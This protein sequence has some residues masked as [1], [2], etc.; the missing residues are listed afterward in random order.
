MV[1]PQ[2]GLPKSL[3]GDFYASSVPLY[4]QFDPETN[5][6]DPDGTYRWAGVTEAAIGS[7]VRSV[8]NGAGGWGDP[9]ERDP[10]LVLRDVRDEYVT[11][12]G[13]NRDYGAV[14]TGDP[15]HHPEDLE[16]DLDAT[17]R[18][19]AERRATTS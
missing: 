2:V 17:A 1:D 5:E 8:S 13:A 16:L 10:R 18:L 19:R 12:E 4:G 6:L 7:V 9:L 3:T 14:I 15:H 11:I